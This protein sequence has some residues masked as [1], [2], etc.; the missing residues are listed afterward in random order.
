MDQAEAISRLPEI[1]T[2]LFVPIITGAVF[3]FIAIGTGSLIA[4]PFYTKSRPP[5]VESFATGC[6]LISLITML[7]GTF[8]LLT[9]QW[10]LGT[11]IVFALVSV[12]GWIKSRPVLSI[13]DGNYRDPVTI[14]LSLLLVIGVVFRIFFYPLFPPIAWDVC[15]YHMPNVLRILETGR[16]TFYPDILYSNAPRATEMLFVWACSWSPLSS[17]QYLNFL[18]YIAILII[19][20]RLGK[21]YLS[22]KIGLF[23]ALVFG[24]LGHVQSLSTQAYNDI[25]VIFYML[26]TFLLLSEGL[27]KSESRKILL[28]GLIIGAAVATKYTSLA[29]ALALVLSIVV[30]HFWK[31]SGIKSVPLKTWAWAILLAFIVAAPWYIRS[32]IWFQNPFYPF[33]WTVFPTTGGPFAFYAEECAID[34]RYMLDQYTVGTRLS[35]GVIFWHLYKQ[36]SVWISIPLC[37]IFFKR[38]AF[39][40]FGF[41]WNVFGSIYWLVFAGGI[42]DDRYYLHLA[43]ISAIGIG[44]AASVFHTWATANRSRLKTLAWVILIFWVGIFGA[45]V[46]KGSPP[47]INEKRDAYIRSERNSFDLISAAN[48][49]IPPGGIAIGINN[50]DG[51]C[52]AD[53]TLYGGTDVGWANHGV[54]DA[55]AGSAQELAG[56]I[57][58]RYNASW[59]IVNETRLADPRVKTGVRVGL[60]LDD[61][62][63][64]QYFTEETRTADG[65]VYSVHTPE[66]ADSH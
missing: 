25:W 66:D 57:S 50:E 36:W 17:A 2:N 56:F 1:L 18:A 15:S 30:M 27:R 9:S 37:L 35:R 48:G 58:N 65:V 53:F 62:A 51:R 39:F 5:V 55:H 6:L 10:R 54:I 61:P 41:L 24:A 11:A 20:V 19:I 34:P 44:Y 40:K 45:R 12:V 42:I 31:P 8:G 23:A 4:R 46:Q 32:F 63:F 60:P 49:V 33:M 47:F 38:S 59:L 26:L 21:L 13:A 16:D 7:L 14:A 3:A 29:T 28:A 43:A 22:E 52:F 64:N